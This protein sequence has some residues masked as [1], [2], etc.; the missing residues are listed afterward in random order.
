MPGCCVFAFRQQLDPLLTLVA[1]CLCFLFLFLVMH[2]LGI[3]HLDL[4]MENC[5]AEY[6][7]LGGAADKKLFLRVMDYGMTRRVGT[8]GAATPM[9]RDD[10]T[11]SS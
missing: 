8:I 5:C 10:T 7:N 6:E 11:V 2:K 1:L 4:S 9:I 3:V